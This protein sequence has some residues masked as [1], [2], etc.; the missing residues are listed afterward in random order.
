LITAWRVFPWNPEADEGDA[1]SPSFVP[2]GQGYGRFDLP[3]ADVGVRYFA[4]S[5]EHAVAE[6]LV[7]LRNQSMDEADLLEYG[8]SLALVDVRVE[9]PVTREIADLCSASALHSLG[10]AP[11]ETAYHDRR[12]TQAISQRI[13]A[14]GFAGLRW[15][16]GFRGEWH[17]VVLYTE[18]ISRAALAFGTPDPLR[19]DHPAVREAADQLGIGV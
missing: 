9:V 11:D 12:T 14:A 5:P 7:R 19:L 18:R 4:E 3:D 15:W 2:G 16:S 10:I 13:H 8:L 6:K 1:F 17:T